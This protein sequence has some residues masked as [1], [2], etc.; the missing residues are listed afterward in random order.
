MRATWLF[1]AAAAAGIAATAAF[2]AP[3]PDWTKHMG[4]APFVVGLERGREE[5]RLTGLPMMLFLT[6]AT[7][8]AC[9]KFGARTWWDPEVKQKVAG[10]T[11]VLLD[12]DTADAD[13]KKK[14]RVEYVP[15]VVWLNHE[16][17]WLYAC[18]GD[19][20]LD[21]FRK[22]AEVARGRCP[23]P[24]EPSE[25]WKALLALRQQ[26]ADGATAKDVK[27]QFAAIAEIRKAKQGEAIQA[28]ARAAE[29]R[30]TTEGLAAVG[31]CA[32]VFEDKKATSGKR[33]EAKKALE[34]L[35]EDYGAG[36]AVAKAA[37]EAL[38]RVTGKKRK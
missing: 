22:E 5:S 2:P 23:A 25:T 4:G 10:W 8:P 16:E 29:E 6:S 11:P 7:D 30:L 13:L 33:A 18:Y 14:Y 35:V 21:I 9:P 26:L 12:F 24:K 37:Q 38:D 34:K 19:A 27:A 3:E 31:Q 20:P 32:A 28:E 17:K 36:H 1:G 15:S